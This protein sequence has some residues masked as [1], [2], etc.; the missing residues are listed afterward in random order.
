MKTVQLDYGLSK[1][2]VDLPDSFGRRRLLR[3]TS[4]VQPREIEQ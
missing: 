1:M 2:S 4:G 3:G